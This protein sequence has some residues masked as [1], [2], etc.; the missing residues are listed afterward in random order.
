VIAGASSSLLETGDRFDPVEQR[1]LLATISEESDRLSRLV[2]NLLTMTRLESGRIEPV[3]EW[4]VVEDLISSALTSLSR[5]IEGRAIEA[6]VPADLPLL[7]VDGRLVELLLINLLDNATRY[8][9]AG[10][11]IEVRARTAG[12]EVLPEVADRGPGL[13]GDEKT[14]AFEKFFRGARTRG[15]HSRG[16]GLGLA[17]CAAVAE[18]HRGSIRVEDREGGGARFVLSLPLHD[19]PPAIDEGA[20]PPGEEG[21]SR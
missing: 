12:N 19:Q 6:R 13:S 1:D 15:D 8:S 17:I 16:A 5:Q 9:P 18:L 3:R 21:A 14:R 2:D 7:Y 10:S 20:P 4:N 11:A